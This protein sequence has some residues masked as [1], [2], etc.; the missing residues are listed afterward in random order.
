MFLPVPA[1]QSCLQPAG[2]LR[3]SSAGAAGAGAGATGAVGAAG[4]AGAGAGE[5]RSERRK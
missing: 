4:A 3:W 5:L 1:V 2:C